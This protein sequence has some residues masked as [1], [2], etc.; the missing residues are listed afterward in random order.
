MLIL[1]GVALEAIGIGFGAMPGVIALG[2][3]T[4][5]FLAKFYTED[6]EHVNASPMDTLDS[7]GAN[8]IQVLAFPVIPQ[9]ISSFVGNNLYPPFPK[10][11]HL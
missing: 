1:M 4:M 6:K 2:F 3:Y 11:P 8:R 5:D 9:V 10:W 7:T